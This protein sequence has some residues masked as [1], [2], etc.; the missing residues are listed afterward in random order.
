MPHIIMLMYNSDNI[1]PFLHTN[2]TAYSYVVE[3][4]CPTLKHGCRFGLAPSTVGE[5]I[6]ITCACNE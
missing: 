4:K 2:D 3:L 6:P 1:Q 5:N